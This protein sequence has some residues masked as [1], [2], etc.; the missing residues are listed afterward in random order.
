MT[1][2]R[3]QLRLGVSRTQLFVLLLQFPEDVINIQTNAIQVVL[4]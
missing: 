2:E 1:C 4:Y 3:S